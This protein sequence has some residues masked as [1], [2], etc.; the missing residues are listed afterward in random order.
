MSVIDALKRRK[1]CVVIGK[2]GV[3]KT[4]VAAATA[5]AFA[6]DGEKTLVFSIDPAPNLGD[7]LG[8]ELSPKPKEVCRN[9]YAAEIDID[10][11]L[12]EFSQYVIE[13][14]KSA[15]KYLSVLALDKY[16]ELFRYTPGM[17]EEAI[18]TYM[19]KMVDKYYGEFDKIVIDTPPTGLALRVLAL[20]KII[21]MWV[22]KLLEIRYA[23]LERRK[24]LY[25]LKGEEPKV[26]VDVEFDPVTKELRAYRSEIEKIYKIL[27]SA[28]ETGYVIVTMPEQLPLAEAKRARDFLKHFGY[29]LAG[30]V[31]N[32][33][34]GEGFPKE[35]L[36]LQKRYIRVI[37]EEFKGVPK[38]IIPRIKGEVIGL[39]TLKDV[40]RSLRGGSRELLET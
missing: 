29:S 19:R 25:K 20:P 1:L 11:A 17:E 34:Y 10:A 9:L 22:D 23:I 39:E 35:V 31:I 16:L 24:T 27:S 28:E 18:L 7:I 4:S 32:R 36:E 6:E 38:A 33:V 8:T 12:K 2:G 37:E 5:L 3:G 21:L 40:A 14:F 15:Y 26:P 13:A 30:V